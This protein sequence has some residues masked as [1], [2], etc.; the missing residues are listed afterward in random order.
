MI[1][2]MLSASLGFAPFPWATDQGCPVPRWVP[3]LQTPIISLQYNRI[4]SN[5]KWINATALQSL[6]SQ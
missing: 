6:Y 1:T 5:L 4:Q 2:K 3:S